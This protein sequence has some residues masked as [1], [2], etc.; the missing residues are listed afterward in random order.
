M[1]ALKQ[2]SSHVN[3]I[4]EQQGPIKISYH[5]DLDMIAQQIEETKSLTEVYNFKFNEELRQIFGESV[6]Q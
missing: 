1:I 5:V 3:V 2:V 6:V 4:K